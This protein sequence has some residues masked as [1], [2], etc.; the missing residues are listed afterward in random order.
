MYSLW[1]DL[2]NGVI[3]TNVYSVS[4]KFVIWSSFY[5]EFYEDTLTTLLRGHRFHW[6]LRDVSY[7]FGIKAIF[8]FEKVPYYFLPFLK[9]LFGLCT[10]VI[11]VRDVS[12]TRS[13]IL[14]CFL[15]SLWTVVITMWE[16]QCFKNEFLNHFTFEINSFKKSEF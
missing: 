6:H 14:I 9:L 16:S 7:V 8:L 4:S 10:S 13:N 5:Q 2:S 12:K 15:L 3:F 11:F 1:R